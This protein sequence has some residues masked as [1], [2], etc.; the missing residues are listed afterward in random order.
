MDF[1]RISYGFPMG[2]KNN[3]YSGEFLEIGDL[4][5]RGQSENDPK[6]NFLMGSPRL[7]RTHFTVFGWGGPE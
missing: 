1:L 2:F 6:T 5:A 3:S 4:L 7:L